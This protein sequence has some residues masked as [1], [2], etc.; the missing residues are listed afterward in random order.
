VSAGIK[1][2]MK[3]K[4]QEEE[5]TDLGEKISKT[6]KVTENT[7]ASG[8]LSGLKLSSFEPLDKKNGRELC[9]SCQK[10]RKFFCYNCFE[11]IGDKEGIPQMDLPVDIEIVRHPTEKISKSSVISAKILAPNCVN[12]SNY[13]EIP[14]FDMES[15]VLLYPKEDAQ[16][17]QDMSPEEFGK[18]KRAVFVDCSWLQTY[19]VLNSDNLMDLKCIK[20]NTEK[21]NFWRYQRN[22][23]DENLA[24]VEAVYIFLKEYI[25]RQKGE[26]NGEA[27]DILYFYTYQYNMIQ[28]RYKKEKRNFPRIDGYIKSAT[29]D[30]TEDP[31]ETEEKIDAEEEGE[32]AKIVEK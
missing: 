8:L 25:T 7:V 2:K 9:P 21:T 17:V 11:L 32:E 6:Q 15:T 12:V 1:S 18:I 13:P 5:V 4:E 14:K 22:V 31:K 30:K 29:K 10:S 24:T 20:I 16:L 27:D 23:S 28:N 26:Y 3:R 19:S